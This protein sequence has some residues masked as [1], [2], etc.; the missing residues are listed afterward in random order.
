MERR[1]G[2]WF[3]LRRRR[4]SIDLRNRR[5]GNGKV[6]NVEDFPGVEDV[7]GVQGPFDGPDHTEIGLIHLVGTTSISLLR[8]EPLRP[9]EEIPEH[10]QCE[11]ARYKAPP[12]R[13]EAQTHA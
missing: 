2:Q 11:F 1:F 10:G 4:A 6:S 7:V 12:H 3:S 8:A 13:R 5:V 9:F